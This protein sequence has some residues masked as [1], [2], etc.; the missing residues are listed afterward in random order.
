ML[1]HLNP[2]KWKVH[3]FVGTTLGA[4]AMGVFILLGFIQVKKDGFEIENSAGQDI[5]ELPER[6]GSD[7]DLSTLTSMSD[8][9]FVPMGESWAIGFASLAAL[10][11]V[12]YVV[13]RIADASERVTREWGI[14]LFAAAVAAV[15]VW[16]DR[17][18]QSGELIWR[19]WWHGLGA[20]A[21]I[22]AAIGLS[23]IYY[24]K[25]KKRR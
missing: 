25:N 6:I 2:S 21:A 15:A 5:C 8:C 23:T 22:I 4:A 13:Y 1:T 11:L 20:A 7:V 12:G 19:F 17:T 3:D 14:V 18:N 16:V 9:G 24:Q 10:A